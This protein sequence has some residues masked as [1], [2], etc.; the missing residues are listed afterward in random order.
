MVRKANIVEVQELA[1]GKGT[2]VVHYIVPEE[3][4]YGHGRMYAKVVLKPNSSVGWHRH[5]GETEPYYILSGEGIFVDDDG[6]RTKVGEGDV[7]TIVPGQ[8]HAIE[9]ASEYVDLVFMALIHKN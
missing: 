2:A 8:C 6:S 7:C 5:V 4:L 1:G 3:E 9:N